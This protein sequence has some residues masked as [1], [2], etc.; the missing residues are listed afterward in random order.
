MVE[1]PVDKEMQ[2][3]ALAYRMLDSRLKDMLQQRELIAE[4]ILEIQTTLLGIDEV[5]KSQG[6]VLFSLGSEAHVQGS[7]KGKSL[8]VEIGA[9]VALEKN[10]DE[11]KSILAKRMKDLESAISSIQNEMEKTSFAMSEIESQ[12]EAEGVE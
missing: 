10:V 7:V 3:K 9:G 2:K 11:A 6:D 12:L 5:M 1:V 8:I 4:K